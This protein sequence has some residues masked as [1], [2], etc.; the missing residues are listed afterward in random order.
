M[1]RLAAPGRQEEMGCKTESLPIFEELAKSMFKKL[2]SDLICSITNIDIHNFALM[3]NQMHFRPKSHC[4][5]CKYPGKSSNGKSTVFVPASRFL[6]S[7]SS[8]VRAIVMIGSEGKSA[9]DDDGGIFFPLTWGGNSNDWEQ[10]TNS[11]P[12]FH[13]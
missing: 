5:T 6:T 12:S 2:T 9:T 7:S 4:T 10:S 8:C 1:G 11:G 3:Q 13:S